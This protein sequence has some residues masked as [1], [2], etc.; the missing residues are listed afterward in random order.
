M[1]AYIIRRLLLVIPEEMKERLLERHEL[2]AKFAQLLTRVGQENSISKDASKAPEA[3]E[4]PKLVHQVLANPRMSG[5]PGRP[6]FRGDPH[7]VCH[8]PP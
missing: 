1:R 3:V 4:A 5:R 2:N 8:C 7:Q 6:R